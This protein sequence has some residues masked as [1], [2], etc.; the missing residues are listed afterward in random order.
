MPKHRLFIGLKI[1]Q[2]IKEKLSRLQ[3][4]IAKIAPSLRLINLR[5]LHITLAFLGYLDG[6]QISKISLILAKIS[7]KFTVF[8]LGLGDICF[9]PSE[10]RA[11]VVAVDIRDAGALVKLQKTLSEELGKLKFI[12]IEKR[13]YHPHLTIARVREKIAKSKVTAIK[14]TRIKKADFKVAEIKLIKSKLLRTGAEYS[15]FK[16]WNLQ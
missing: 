15:V 9:F 4:E 14:K 8:K 10:K 13:E 7:K 11:R 12:K 1:P 2:K 5:N 16:K 6:R 3:M